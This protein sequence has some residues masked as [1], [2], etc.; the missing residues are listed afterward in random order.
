M[1]NVFII[2]GPS[3]VGEDSV[4]EGLRDH[5]PIERVITTRTR[6]MRPGES[7]GNPYYFISENE[8]KEKLAAHEF[9]EYAEQYNGQLSGVTKS[10]IDRV[11]HSGKVGIWKIEYKGVMTAKHLFPGIIAIMLTAPIDVL[12]DRI[13]RRDNPDEKLLAERM[14]YT[15]EWLKH[16]DIYDYQV[17]NKEGKLAE[18]IEQV[19]HIIKQHIEQ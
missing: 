8:F 7:Q 19:A 17:E 14:A 12:E 13:R 1:K 10:E 11:S 9:I 3:G 15:R 18:T 2:S 6:A 5:F 16:L 4:I